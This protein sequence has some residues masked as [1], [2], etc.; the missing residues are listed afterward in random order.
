MDVRYAR[1]VTV[2]TIVLI[3]IAIFVFGT[4]WL[5]GK[6]LGGAD[7]VWVQFRNTAGLKEAAPV[8]VSG[9]P[10]GKVEEITFVEPG[11]VMVGLALPETIRPKLDASAEIVSI[12]L[13][14]DYAVDFEP[15]QAPQP[16]PE[17]RPIIGTQDAG[18]TGLA[19]QLGGRADTL[20][21]NM[22]AFI[23]PETAAEFRQTMRS[24]NELM[25]GLSRT[26]PA[27]AAELNRTMAAFRQ[28][29]A[30]LNRTLANPSL[31]QALDRSD[32][33]TANLQAMTAQLGATAARL[34]TVMRLVQQGE[35]TLGKLA[36][37]SM[38][39]RNIVGVTA[40]LDSLLVELRKNPGR[41]NISPTI[42]LF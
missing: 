8:R 33:L 36:T 2:G 18:L 19:E 27:T 13:V 40:S 25:Q 29:S 12:S 20:L 28:T 9:V 32:S 21:A 1:E 42:K 7:L 11:K 38:L 4:M 37:D 23:N 39:Y 24:T 10:V 41:M 5:S 35:G 31:R 17:N 16:L 30:E 6:S 22:E 14:G 34:D 26:L 15:G 3:A